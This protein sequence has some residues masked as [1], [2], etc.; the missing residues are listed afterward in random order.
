MKLSKKQ[1]HFIH[2][3]AG[4]AILFDYD[5]EQNAVEV[6]R[7]IDK[8]MFTKDNQHSCFSACHDPSFQDACIENNKVESTY[9]I[10]SIVVGT[11]KPEVYDN[12]ANYLHK[13]L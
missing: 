11:A 12:I 9:M 10:E 7:H 8:K 5:G 2:S 1:F 6:F 3:V 4:Y 13:I